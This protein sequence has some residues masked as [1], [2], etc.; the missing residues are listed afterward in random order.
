MKTLVAMLSFGPREHLSDIAFPRTAHWASRQGYS[1]VLIKEPLHHANEKPHFGKL[2]I[3][4]RF[5]GF[6]RYC[7]ID[8]DL[9]ISRNAPELPVLDEGKIGLVADAEQRHTQNPLVEWT[10]NTGFLLTQ[11]S[12]LDLLAKACARGQDESVWGIADQGSL[13][14]VAWKEQRVQRLDAS[15][16]YQCVLEFFLRGRGWEHWRTSRTY[17]LSFYVRLLLHSRQPQI[18]AVRR[19]WGLHLI[20]A[21]YPRFFDHILP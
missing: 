21:P 19:S 5:P 1:V 13:N 10:G 9:L 18:Q 16:N 20:R 3:P 7:I 12:S 2:R 15:W 11:P 4:E 8:D 17:R 6:D 14:A